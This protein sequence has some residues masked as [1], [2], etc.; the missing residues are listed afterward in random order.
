MNLIEFKPE[1]HYVR[2]MADVYDYTGHYTVS[3]GEGILAL[4]VVVTAGFH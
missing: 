4:W 1:N 3:T 2:E